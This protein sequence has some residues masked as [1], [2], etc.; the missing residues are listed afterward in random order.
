MGPRRLLQVEKKNNPCQMP[1]VKRGRLL[2][3]E[4]AWQPRAELRLDT[5][6][7]VPSPV[8]LP[9]HWASAT[10]CQLLKNKSNNITTESVIAT[11]MSAC[12]TE[13]GSSAR[14]TQQPWHWLLRGER[15]CVCKS[16]GKE[17]ESEA[18]TCLL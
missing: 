7:L 8:L 15:R 14:H 12:V 16:T 10:R 11:C 4:V 6:F 3:L 5:C 17:T 9:V 13:Q 1:S 2:T 18:Q